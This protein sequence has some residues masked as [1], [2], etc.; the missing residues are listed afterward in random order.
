MKVLRRR[1][2][3]SVAMFLFSILFAPL[4]VVHADSSTQLPNAASAEQ[5]ADMD[6][7]ASQLVEKL[8]HAGIKIVAVRRFFG[9]KTSRPLADTLSDELI[10]A[11]A[12]TSGDIHILDQAELV[13]AL[14]EKKWMAIDLHDPLVF[15]SIAVSLGADAVIHGTLRAD[16]KFVQLL[17]KAENVSTEKKIAE[18]NAKVLLPQ[19]VDN[20]P[21]SPV[22]DPVTGPYLPGF[23]GVTAPT[24]TYCPQ[25]EF[26][27]E[28]RQKKISRA[29]DVFRVTVRSDGRLAD[30]RVLQPAGYGLDENSATVL[31]R[32]QLSPARLVDGTAVPCRINIEVTYDH[33]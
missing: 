14:E 24:C 13:K 18:V 21:D 32:W 4:S 3:G 11:F 29:Q 10:S 7:L 33:K 28:A 25:P 1:P 16:G 15:N 9:T 22:Q 17:L 12:K 6:L 23:G 27:S 5:N 26:S 2:L 31:L 30:I 19:G 8:K 20:S